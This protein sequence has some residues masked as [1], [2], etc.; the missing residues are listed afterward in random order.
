MFK[1]V[2]DNTMRDD[3]FLPI[4]QARKDIAAYTY[5]YHVPGGSNEETDPFWKIAKYAKT[6]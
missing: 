1:D 6:F 2:K 4:T 5:A 3:T